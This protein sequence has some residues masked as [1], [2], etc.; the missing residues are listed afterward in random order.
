TWREV[1]GPLGARGRVVA[2]DRP[3]FGLSARPLPPAGARDFPSGDDPYGAAAQVAQTIALMDALAIDRAVLVGS[4]AGGTLAL[5]VAL[6]RPERVRALVLLAPAVYTGGP[7]PWFAPLLRTPQLRRIGPLLLRGLAERADAFTEAAWH[8]PGRVDAAIARGYA[9]ALEVDDWDR[10]LWRYT[11][12]F[13]GNDDLPPRLADLDLPILVIAGDD[14]RV[15]PTAESE[16]LAD[17][18]PSAELV[19]IGAC[20][21]LPHEECPAPTLAAI[22]GFLDRLE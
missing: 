9:R 18:L 10:A 21:H 22:D 7:P 13:S 20:G 5:R 4:S 1:L 12:A 11:L 19:V 3:A 8:D 6:A 14:D 15:V 17:A 2:F 16:R